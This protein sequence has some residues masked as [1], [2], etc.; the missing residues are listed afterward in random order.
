MSENATPAVDGPARPVPPAS[1]LPWHLAGIVATVIGGPLSF[2]L[3]ASAGSVL[4]PGVASGPQTLLTDAS[5]DLVTT[6]W[7]ALIVSGLILAGQCLM[8]ARS[9]VA[10]ATA[11][12]VWLLAGIV[13]EFW[14]VPGWSLRLLPAQIAG[15]PIRESVPLLLSTGGALLIGTALAAVAISATTARQHGRLIERAEHRRI[16]SGRVTVPPRSRLA[17]HISAPV[18]GLVLAIVGVALTNR[19]VS[20]SVFSGVSPSPALMAG[21]VLT[22]AVMTLTGALSSLGPAVASTAWLASFVQV[23]LQHSGPS[24]VSRL[25]EWAVATVAP[26]NAD[27]SRGAADATG[28]TWAIGAV[29][30]GGALGVHFARRDGRVTQHREFNLAPQPPAD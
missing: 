17:A 26:W 27:L 8:A 28:L 30:I 23:Q 22:V 21:A 14:A 18:L 6:A 24:A 11:G 3:L 20:E 4:L 19:I 10:A 12:A 25:G 13:T 2:A 29:L 9:A 16:T 5:D 1:R 7:V 15:L